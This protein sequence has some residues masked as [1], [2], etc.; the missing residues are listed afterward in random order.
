MVCHGHIWAQVRSQHLKLRTHKQ[1]GPNHLVLAAGPNHLVLAAGPNHL[2][3][4]AGPN[5]LV[6]AAG[7]NHLV[8]AAGPNHLVPAAGPNHLVLAAGLS[9]ISMDNDLE[10]Y[11]GLTNS[12]ENC[13][14]EAIQTVQ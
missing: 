7:P 9:T 11:F 14:M 13:L 12:Q 2:V 1:N 4:A 8:L 6:L 3:L 10:I 5:H